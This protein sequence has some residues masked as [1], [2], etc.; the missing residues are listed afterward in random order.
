[1]SANSSLPRSH[2]GRNGRWWFAACA[3]LGVVLVAVAGCGTPPAFDLDELDLTPAHDEMI[4]FPL[5]SYTVPIP[6]VQSKNRDQPVRANRLEFSFQL[7]ALV[8]PDQ[9]SSLADAWER[10]EGKIRDRVIRVCRNATL[11]DLQ[12]PELATLKSHLAD[13]VQAELGAKGVRRLLI[14]EVVSQEL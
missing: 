3:A 11:G 9:Q 10:H 5:G 12:E 13:A 1:M 2:R 7:Y 6:V 8:T 14:T 4:E